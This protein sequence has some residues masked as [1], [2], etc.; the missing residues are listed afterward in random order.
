MIID[1]SIYAII[2]QVVFGKLSDS[3]GKADSKMY[4]LRILAFCVCTVFCTVFSASADFEANANSS[5]NL[6][7]VK[8]MKDLQSTLAN[9]D[10]KPIHE[11]LSGDPTSVL[12]LAD[13]GEMLE[14]SLVIVK[15]LLIKV[16]EACALG[17]AW[18]YVRQPA[19]LTIRLLLLGCTKFSVLAY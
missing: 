1:T 3:I 5:K 19:A 13:Y 8:Y 17:H 15:K 6:P 10:G 7:R 18:A 4:Q 14:W 12:C 16:V 9:A 11:D 2:I